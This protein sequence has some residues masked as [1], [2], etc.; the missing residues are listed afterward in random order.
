MMERR[1]ACMRKIGRV[2]DVT[3][4]TRW[5]RHGR[6]TSRIRSNERPTIVRYWKLVASVLGV[7][8]FPYFCVPFQNGR[9]CRSERGRPG[10]EIM[11]MGYTEATLRCLCSSNGELAQLARALAWHARGHRFDSGILHERPPFWWPFSL[12]WSVEGPMLSS[13][14]RSCCPVFRISG[15]G[16][17]P[18]LTGQRKSVRKAPN[19]FVRGNSMGSDLSTRSADRAGT[20][21]LKAQGFFFLRR[22]SPSLMSSPSSLMEPLPG[23]SGSTAPSLL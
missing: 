15:I 5:S 21:P 14:C 4:G 7:R 18:L 6:A 23:P 22:P 3:K 8:T 11:E 12:V 1:R 9:G 16:N 10:N 13:E 17:G 19:A 20:Q 2:E